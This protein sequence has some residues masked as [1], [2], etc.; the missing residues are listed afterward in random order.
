MKIAVLL[1]ISF[2]LAA[3]VPDK[4]EGPKIDSTTQREMDL[5]KHRMQG[6]G[7]IDPD[8]ERGFFGEK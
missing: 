5:H 6:F 2:F 3:C 1:I 7:D 4:E 8:S